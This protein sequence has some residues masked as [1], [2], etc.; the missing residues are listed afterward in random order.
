MIA[1]SIGMGIG[2]DLENSTNNNLKVP[3]TTNNFKLPS[4]Y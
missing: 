1:Y 4:I 3:I 2:K